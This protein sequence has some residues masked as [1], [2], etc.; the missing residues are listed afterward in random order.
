MQHEQYRVH[1]DVEGRH[2]W[3]VARRRILHRLVEQSLPPDRDATVIDVGCGTGGNVAALAASYRCVGID[4]SSEAIE[5]AKARFP[6]VRLIAGRAPQDL[7]AEFA[8]AKLVM[9]NDVLEHVDEDR[10]MFAELFNASSPGCLFLIT[11]PADPT[12]WSEHDE[13]FGHRRRY[14]AAR[15][16]EVWRGLP[17]ET[18][19]L[20]HFNA[21]LY[22]IVK[23]IRWWNRRRGRAMGQSGTDF[24]LPSRPANALL[25]SIFAG[26]AGRLTAVLRGKKRGYRAGVSLVALLRRVAQ[27]PPAVA[28]NPR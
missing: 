4:T 26:E 21:R 16:E 9:L 7:E 17:A 23:L 8:E 12:L 22:P 1:A 15:L 11:V 18:L 6:N 20:S 14:D 13:S 5:L 2:W 27:P 24:R 19:M 25:T 10:A 3:F 28:E